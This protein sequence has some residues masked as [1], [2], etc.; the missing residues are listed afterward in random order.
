M[1][2]EVRALTGH[3]GLAAVRKNWRK[4]S[5]GYLFLL[6][7][8][9]LYGIFMIYPFVQSVYL[10]L[11]DWDGAQPVKHFVGLRNFQT[12][13]QDPLVWTS[14]GHNLIWVVIGTIVPIVIGLL[15]AVLLW[16][17]PRGFTIF[18]TI[19]FMPQVLPAVVIGIVWSWIY[20]PVFGLLNQALTAVGL[21]SWTHGWLGEPS[22]ALY[23]VL[24]A[25]IWAEIGFVF[26]IVLAGLQ[27]VS[28]ELLE[29][30]L[31]D[32]ANAWQ[33]FWH[34]TIP[35]LANVLTTVMVLLLIGGF[36]VFDIVFIMTGGGPANSTEL[37]AT[38]TYKQA[39]TQ[40]QVGYAA[41]LSLVLTAI[42]LIASVIL[43]R[44]RERG[45]P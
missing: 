28:R 42:S 29:A 9:I 45:E 17:R 11:T 5:V 19:Y 35:Q 10:S 40:N 31:I 34:V 22:L 43:I 15:L 21:D 38:Y 12:L 30:A 20:N 44:V 2:A 6:P 37:I 3:G 39:F 4:Y 26:V 7:A 1:M 27:N 41:A 33:Q 36:S 25:A 14:L 8:A 13:I 32:G 24:A 16:S 18:R 23:A